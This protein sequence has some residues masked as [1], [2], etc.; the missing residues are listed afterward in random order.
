MATC[1]R[2]TPNATIHDSKD[3]EGK[4]C[5]EVRVEWKPADGSLDRPNTGGYQLGATLR[6]AA[7]AARLVRAIN[8]GA[9]LKFVGV[10]VDIGGQSYVQSQCA[11]R[12]RCLNAD[13][14]SIGY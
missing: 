1:T 14:K 9:A 6:D 7:L 3:F 13:L 11:V 2:A 10:G 5:I 4:P 8:D 12:M